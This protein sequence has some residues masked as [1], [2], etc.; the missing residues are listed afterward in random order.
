MRIVHEDEK[1]GVIEVVPETLDDLWHLSH[2]IEEG[3]LLSARTTRRIQDTSG[4]KIRSDRGVKKT[5]YLGIRIETVSFHIYTGKLRATGVI[6]RGPEDLVPLGSHHTLE[7]KLNTPLRIKKDSWSRWTL[8]R[9]QEAVEASKHIRALIVVIEDDVADIGV[10]RQYGVEYHGPITGHIPGKR[11]QQRDRGKL[12]LEFYEMIVDALKKYGELETIIIA[13][14]GFYKS[15]FH[16]YLLEKHP[17][18]G[19]KAVVENTGTGGRSG[20]YEVLRKGTVER[21]SSENRVA[22]EVRN[23]NEVLERLARDPETV[24]YGREE[25]LDAIN[26]G[27]VERLLVLD[28][29]VSREDIEGYLDIVESMGGSV[30]LIS[31]EHEGGKQLESLGGLAGI[32]RFRIS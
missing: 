9:L 24:V 18:I 1:N 23:V 29:V 4:E 19:R 12:R 7:V 6:E 2:I 25:V 32:L 28:R 14:P 30:V 5:F 11:M 17:E 10:I 27:A 13:G 15:D 21:V 26:M 8:K 3:D 20:I 16:E 31:S 22:A